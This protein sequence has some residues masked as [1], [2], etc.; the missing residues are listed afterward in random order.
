LALEICRSR[1][2]HLPKCE[3]VIER[4]FRRVHGRWRGVI[5]RRGQHRS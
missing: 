4:I 1:G 5:W 2:L 3:E